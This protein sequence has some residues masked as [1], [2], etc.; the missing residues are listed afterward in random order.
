M[1]RS[2]LAFWVAACAGTAAVAQDRPS[3]ASRLDP[4]TLEALRPLLAAAARDSIPVL[5][6]ENKALEGAAKG[7]PPVRILEGVRRLGEEL[8][9]VR[10]VL[11]TTALPSPTSEEVIA[12]ADARRRGVPAEEIAQLRRDASPATPL[13]VSLT[14]LGD[15]VQR[16]IP[17]D[18]ARAVIQRLTDASLPGDQI[19]AIPGRVDVGMRVG[20]SAM[21]ALRESIPRT[22]PVT[23]PA[24]P[25]GRGQ[26]NR[27]DNPGQGAKKP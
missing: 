20:A 13:V 23:V 12:A 2:L 14:V 8:R 6:L 17:A 19:A 4:A 9:D 10:Q 22:I 24:S 11:R 5:A 25:R 21:D 7:V 15:L 26:E 1:P 27:P 18:Y 16:G 3:L